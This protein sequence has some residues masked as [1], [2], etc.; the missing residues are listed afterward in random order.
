M[1]ATEFDSHRN[2]GRDDGGSKHLW[3]VCQFLPDYT[4]KHPRGQPSCQKTVFCGHYS[5]DAFLSLHLQLLMRQPATPTSMPL[6]LV[7]VSRN[8]AV[9]NMTFY[10]N[11]TRNC[12]WNMCSVSV[13]FRLNFVRIQRRCV[14]HSQFLNSSLLNLY[15][16][17]AL[18]D[19]GF[20]LA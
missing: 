12:S 3:N 14:I 17:V 5:T 10:K 15:P 16:L 4:S 2:E 9:T 1:S 19:F 11:E 6:G 8:M 7:P 13:C 18:N 20:S